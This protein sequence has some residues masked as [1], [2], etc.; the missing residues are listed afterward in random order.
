MSKGAWQRLCE[1]LTTDIPIA[2]FTQGTVDTCKTFIELAKSINEN[3]SLSEL[4]PLIGQISSV[5]DV[6]NLPIV[7]VV[8]SALPVVGIASK[9]L[10][11]SLDTP[12]PVKE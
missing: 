7:Q 6:L 5:L 8:G 2:E 1:I 12:F 4:A 3:R 9:L 10:Q 11:F